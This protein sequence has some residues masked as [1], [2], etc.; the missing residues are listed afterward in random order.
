MIKIFRKYHKWLGVIFAYIILSF[1]FSGII[2]NH[3]NALSV[4]DV[5]RK[6]LPKEY[7]YQNWNNAAV[8][9]TL[10]ISSDQDIDRFIV[11]TMEGFYYSDDNF[12]TD[13][14]EF[15]FQPPVSV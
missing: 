7:R 9:S 13:L 10:R 4:I 8:K 3:R 5:N 6:L 1:V 12:K 15:N 14:K 2:L 11:S